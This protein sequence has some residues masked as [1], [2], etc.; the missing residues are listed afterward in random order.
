MS[1]TLFFRS[2]WLTLDKR[3]K[4]GDI[5]YIFFI[6]ARINFLFYYFVSSCYLLALTFKSALLYFKEMRLN[7]KMLVMNMLA[8]VVGE[9][10]AA[11]VQAIDFEQ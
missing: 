1:R 11:S 8:M 3:K 2:M 4:I 6:K 7:R 5:P 9:V 10:G